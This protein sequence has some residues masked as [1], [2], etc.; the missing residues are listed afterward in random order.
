MK[1]ADV[2]TGD[3]ISVAGDTSV[4][5]V[6]RLLLDKKISAVP[7]VDGKG[8]LLGIVSE[9]DLL[10]RVETNTERT[11]SRWL[12]LVT[13]SRDLAAEYVK[14]HARR[15]SDIMTTNVI[16]ASETTSLGDI[17]DMLEAHKI[18]RVPI[19]RDNIVIGIV[20]RANLL[21]ALVAMADGD[22]AAELDD[23]AILQKLSA[24]LHD[25]KWA[26]STGIEIQVRNGVVHLSGTVMTDSARNALRIAAEGVPGVRAVEDHMVHAEPR[27]GM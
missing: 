14:S 17:V 9:G 5:D 11:R 23:Q 19:V 3:V 10:R 16:T 1:A 4:C 7:V 13:T 24:E 15:A 18:K 6:A 22:V 26:K 21:K 27:P 12:E 8:R 25:R 2:R 20:S